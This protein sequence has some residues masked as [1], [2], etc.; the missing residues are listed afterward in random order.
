M[1]RPLYSIL[2]GFGPCPVDIN[3]PAPETDGP[4]HGHQYINDDFLE[5]AQTILMKFQ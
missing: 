1:A 5:N 4:S 2:K 3:I